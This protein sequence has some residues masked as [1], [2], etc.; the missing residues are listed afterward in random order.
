M[1]RWL[2]PLLGVMVV[3]AGHGQVESADEVDDS[4][5]R[6][7][8]LACSIA[9]DAGQ[10]LDCAAEVRRSGDQRGMLAA[11]WGLDGEFLATDQ[12]PGSVTTW[13]VDDPPSGSH[14]VDLIVVDP[15]SSATVEASVGITVGGV[16]WPW[17]VWVAFVA[18]TGVIVG[19]IAWL[20]LRR[21]TAAPPVGKCP[22]CSADLEGTYHFCPSCGAPAGAPQA[23]FCPSCGRSNDPGDRFCSVCGSGLGAG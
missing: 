9:D 11:A 10:R 19:S 16:D 2:L 5:F 17:Y 14:R 7:T 3:L 22:T 13:A 20:L 23:A 21:R 1:L 18:L 12:I 15:E 8:R 6:I 4:G